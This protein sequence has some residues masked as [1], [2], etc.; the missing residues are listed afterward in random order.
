[1]EAVVYKIR[2]LKSSPFQIQKSAQ[3]HRSDIE[4]RQLKVCSM[5]FELTVSLMRSLEMIITVAPELFKDATHPNSELLTIRVCQIINQLL[6][7]VTVPP[8]SFQYVIDLCL[9][10]LSAVT[11]FGII[12][13]A[14]GILLA[15]LSDELTSDDLMRV[16]PI[17]KIVLNDE[18]FQIASLEFALGTIRT[19]I[20]RS[21]K[22]PRGN[23]DPK[24]RN[25]I[26][27]LTNQLK[28]ETSHKSGFDVPIIKF[29]L[30]DC[31][32]LSTSVL[33]TYNQFLNG[34]FFRHESC[35]RRGDTKCT[36]DD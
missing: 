3:E 30:N 31:E 33:I 36:N 27:P 10:D 32:S 1:M 34:F 29:N 22:I 15:L 11:H 7:R 23:F 17:S 4:P 20:Q 35:N 28:L 25:N 12:S 19:P 18:C 24:T 16:P 26:D 21:E 5:C 13:A 6:S 2:T 14:L 8:G 9:P